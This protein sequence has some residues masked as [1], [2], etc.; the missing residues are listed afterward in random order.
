MPNEQVAMSGD[1]ASPM[2]RA[3]QEEMLDLRRI[4]QAVRR[5]WLLI[6][7][8]SIVVLVATFMLYMSTR[9]TYVATA[10]LMVER[11]PDEVL[12]PANE[13]Q[14][15]FPADSP[16]VDT[17]VA[18]I[19][20]PA[21]LGRVVDELRLTRDPEFNP[22][23]T[24]PATGS[25]ATPAGARDR[26]IRI[27]ASQLDVRRQGVSYAIDVHVSSHDPATAARVADAVMNAYLDQQ[28][29]TR[30]GTTERAARLL[31][32]RLEELR[33]QVVAAES[34]VADYRARNQLFAASDTSSIT[35]QQ[36]SLLDTELAEARARQAEADARVSAAGRR[37]PDTFDAAINSTVVS[38][39]RQQRA[40]LS[41]T[42]AD[43]SA[44][45]GPRHPDLVRANE[46]VAEID[47]QIQGELSRIASSL[48]TEASVARQ[49]TAS[50]G[51]SIGALQGRLAVDT[52]AA[53]RLNELERNAESA[54]AIYQAFLDN[55]RQALARQGTESSGASAISRA[56]VPVL[57]SA[58]NPL[59][60]LLLGLF[61][62]AMLSGIAVVV[63]E[64]R[65]Q[66]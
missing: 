6:A 12:R 55:F 33:G 57:P 30:T 1:S 34:A 36:L 23:L 25:P 62:A 59:M 20:S 51:G 10:Q 50:I 5:G 26:A 4:W 19:R 47:S 37:R 15:V 7:I 11:I 42:A 8:V 3:E 44:R 49:R 65:R 29:E 14:P 22:D 18:V 58:P 24:G 53:V 17:A 39:L 2:R 56:Q 52:A 32:G 45:Y 63:N 64:L 28:R 54:R 48:A 38:G 9:P 13:D 43:L 61:A 35:Q 46:Q 31:G 41:A 27:L 21:L 40:Q 66:G 60:Y 16:T